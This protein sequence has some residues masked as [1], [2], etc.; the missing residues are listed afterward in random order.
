M[1]SLFYSIFKNVLVFCFV[2]V[3][4][5]ANNILI[6]NSV[7]SIIGVG[8][9]FSIFLLL[10]PSILKSL[11]LPITS[12]SLLM[13]NFIVGFVFFFTG[14]YLFNFLK[15]P[16][17]GIID[18]GVS[19]I[20]PIYIQDKTVSLLFLTLFSTSISWIFDVVSKNK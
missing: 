17:K 6:N 3:V 9:V 7:A 4:F 19:F 1:N 5:G 10:V 18:F 16:D 12:G 20:A 2:V 11:K 13:M 8:I 15:I 14:F